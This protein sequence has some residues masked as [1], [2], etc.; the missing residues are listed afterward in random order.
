MLWY[1]AENGRQ[2]G[3]VEE[4][5][6]DDLV[7]TG[8]VRDETLV[9]CEGM[10][11]WQAHSVARGL[12]PPAPPP[13]PVAPN[14][15]PPAAAAAVGGFCSECGR[16]FPA[17]SLATIGTAAVCPDCKPFYLRRI[18]AGGAQ[19]IPAPA[20]RYAGF[21][22]RFLAIII[23]G[24]IIGA[25]NFVLTMPFRMTTMF[26]IMNGVENTPGALATV[27][28][29]LGLSIVIGVVLVLAYNAYFV[30]KSGATPGKMVLGLKIIRPDGSGIS[31]G[32]AI[33]R[34]FAQILSGMILYI[35]FIIAAFDSQ[36]RALHD[37]LADTRV[38]YAR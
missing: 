24:F 18:Q 12:R 1:Y 14:P 7:R 16:S 29:M 3:P 5:A 6:L 22:I 23:D 27:F 30:S 17:S 4:S 9:W 32:R 11:N 28:G 20:V 15:I 2:A 33:G 19:P 25:I 36:K 8:V 10:P 21:W 38:I 34:Y 35:G 37:H 26:H 13:P 31:V